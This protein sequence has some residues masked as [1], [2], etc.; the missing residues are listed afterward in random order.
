MAQAPLTKSQLGELA[1]DAVIE[2]DAAKTK[3]P[4][5][6]SALRQFMSSL[7][8]QII[9][10]NGNKLL[11]D[12]TLYPFYSYALHQSAKDSFEGRKNFGVLMT[13]ILGKH[14]FDAA[15]ATDLSEIRKFCL[16]FHEA[17]VSSFMNKHSSTARD[18]DGF[19]QVVFSASV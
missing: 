2:I 4:G 7:G 15:K 11:R 9:E 16:A 14:N 1:L 18:D 17:I 10:D 19:R 3:P 6:F 8:A 13:E 12:E 5:D